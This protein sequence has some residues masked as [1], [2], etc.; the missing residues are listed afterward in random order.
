MGI[1]IERK[2]LVNPDLLP[3][4]SGGKLISQGYIE[5]TSKTVV[6]ARVKGQS[7]YLTLKGEIQGLSCPEFEYEIPRDDAIKI[8]ETLC[9]GKTLEK[10]RYEILVGEHTWELDVFEGMNEGLIVAEI[11]LSSEHEAFD[12]PN[13]VTEEVTGQPQYY[14]VNLLQNPYSS[15]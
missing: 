12:T 10:T 13:W 15:W 7:G 5:T 11:E 6:R 1:E 9:T 14:N 3:T 2:F 4:L 8:I